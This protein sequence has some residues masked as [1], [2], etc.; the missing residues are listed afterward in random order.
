MRARNRTHRAADLCVTAGYGSPYLPSPF[1]SRPRPFRPLRS[2][3]CPPPSSRVPQG[4]A[5]RTAEVIVAYLNP[6]GG[7]R[8]LCALIK[9]YARLTERR[10]RKQDARFLRPSFLSIRARRDS[11]F[12]RRVLRLARWCNKSKRFEADFCL[13]ST[14]SICNSR[15]HV[16][17]TGSGLQY[18]IA[19]SCRLFDYTSPRP[20]YQRRHLACNFQPRKQ[21][22]CHSLTSD[23]AES[24]KRVHGR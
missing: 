19:S 22:T 7:G 9:C 20:Q 18:K 23:P 3:G 6:A 15:L 14:V 8:A 13:K 16:S 10:A 17:T 11:S 4:E 1:L 21:K 5:K 2:A 24:V 12:H